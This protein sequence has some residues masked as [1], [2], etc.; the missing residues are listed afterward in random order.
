MSERQKPSIFEVAKNFQEDRPVLDENN[1]CPYQAFRLVYDE[2]VELQEE[3]TLLAQENST[4]EKVAREVNDVV[5]LCFSLYRALGVDPEI[6]IREQIGRNI[7]K[8]QARHFQGN[9]TYEQGRDL[10]RSN[11]SD[12]EESDYYQDNGNCDA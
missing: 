3:L 2:V 10:A 7:L 11:W 6:S 12:E 9:M 1:R 4:P 8:Y 5:L